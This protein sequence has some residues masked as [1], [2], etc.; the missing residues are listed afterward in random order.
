VTI[1][2]NPAVALMDE[3]VI[4]EMTRVAEDC[5]AVNLAQGFPEMPVPA[6]VLA[7]AHAALDAGHNRYSRTWGDASLRRE[8]AAFVARRWGLAFDPE[9]ELVVTCGASEAIAASLLA[10]LS[11][12]DGVVIPEPIYENYLPAARLASARPEILPVDPFSGDWSVARLEEALSR[13]RVMILNTP[14]NPSGKVWKREELEVVAELVERND[15]VLVT[16]ETYAFILAPSETHVPPATVRRLAR[17]TVTICSFS[18][19]YAVTGWRVGFA[20][21]PAP[22]MG[23]IRTVH[24]FLTVCAPAPF[25]LALR[26]ALVLPDDY[27]AAMTADYRRRKDILANGLREL[28]WRVN[29]PQGTYFLLVDISHL[30][31]EDDREWAVALARTRGVAGVPGSSFLWDGMPRADGRAP[32]R[33]GRFLRL[34]FGKAEADLVEAL[35]RLG[36]SSR[37]AA[38]PAER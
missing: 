2:L 5:G 37:P 38:P 10:L 19:T 9:V 24:D 32:D 26:E 17:R 29:D 27:Y 36:P 1:S 18:K 16:D 3:S 20:A 8:L 12:G 30:G 15:A 33:R 34:S 35:H 21:A 23:A 25:Q 22:L 4:R 31:I 28:G 14:A 11:P 13:S 6:R 7:A